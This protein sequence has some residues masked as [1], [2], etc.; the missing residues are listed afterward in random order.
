MPVGALVAAAAD[1][2]L[3]KAHG[4]GLVLANDVCTTALLNATPSPAPG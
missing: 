1:L 2:L 4:Y 3:A